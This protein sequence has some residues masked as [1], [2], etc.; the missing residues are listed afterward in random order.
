MM[1]DPLVVANMGKM[2]LAMTSS[3]IK[4][5]S[6]I[7]T[8]SAVKPRSDA[9]S[10]PQGKAMILLPFLSWICVLVDLATDLRRMGCFRMWF[11][12]IPNIIMLWRR[13]LLT[14]SVVV[15]AFV[16]AK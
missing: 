9:P 8:K 14:M 1:A 15:L 13:P 7:T 12:M 5:A 4:A 16:K 2:T 10:G 3:G 11:S 6:S